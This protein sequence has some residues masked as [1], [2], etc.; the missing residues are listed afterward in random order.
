MKPEL[1]ALGDRIAEQAFH[2]DAAMFRLLRDLRAFD[3]A[4]GWHQAG[5]RSCA[6]WLSWRVGWD[7][8]TA[9]E[10]VRVAR[11]LEELP[12]L[13][14]ELE[15]GALS[16]S[17]IRAIT[18]VATPA[19]EDCLI[20]F[21]HKTTA[22]QLEKICRQYRTVQRLARKGAGGDRGRRMVARRDL[23]DGMV[24]I[25][26]VLHPEEAAVVWAA[27]ERSA[28]DVSVEAP[29]AT[30]PAAPPA[31]PTFDRADGLVAMAQA[32]VRGDRPDRSPIEVVMTV[33]QAALTVTA[34]AES[35]DQ[36]GSFGDGGHVSA[37]AARR[38][39][40]DAGVVEVTEDAMGRP[41]SV[42]RKTRTIPPAIKRALLHR[43][44]TC[45]FPGCTNRLYV[46]GHHIEHWAQGGETCLENLVTLCSYHHVF[47]H[48]HG[49]RVEMRADGPVFFNPHGLV[50]RDVPLP[51]RR[52]HLA[53]EL[54]REENRELDIG[55]QTG[56][57]Q[58]DGWPV[59]YGLVQ[60]DLYHLDTRAMRDVSSPG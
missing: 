21:A 28:K 47:L 60:R 34:E 41:L 51:P 39:C 15:R 12:T 40:C 53:W 10:H 6:H 8:A 38:L 42:G 22:A 5:A 17:K 58:W 13:G 27:L 20:L 44:Q 35:I 54:I 18:R 16:Y 29:V 32:V 9:R 37:E 55:P 49:Y 2:L 33:P 36:L 25:E 59:D 1:V 24:R 31:A 43:D 3:A 50:V 46:E 57:C 19:T 30:P 52:A 26:A 11:R 45:R 7:L 14:A 56:Q 48:E 23:D 4:G